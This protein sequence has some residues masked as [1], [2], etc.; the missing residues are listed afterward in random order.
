MLWHTSKK[1]STCEDWESWRQ[2][3]R[4]LVPVFLELTETKTGLKFSALSNIL[5]R[6]GGM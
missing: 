6:F 3:L 2:N 4:A 1:I 5:L